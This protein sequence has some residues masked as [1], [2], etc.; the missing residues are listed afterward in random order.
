MFLCEFCEEHL[1]AASGKI[2]KL[3]KR[4]SNLNLIKSSP[5]SMLFTTCVIKVSQMFR[6]KVSVLE[7]LMKR[8]VQNK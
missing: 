3:L 7:T 8:K 6:K 5:S 1:R 4:T 2:R